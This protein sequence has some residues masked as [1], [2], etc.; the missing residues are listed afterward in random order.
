MPRP[1]CSPPSSA[2]IRST[3]SSP[4]ACARSPISRRSTRATYRSG[5]DIKVH[6]TLANGKPY[7][8]TGDWSFVSNQV[9]QQTDTVSVRA[10]FPNPQR[11]LVDGAFVTV[12]VEQGAPEPRLV[13]PRSALQLD[14]I[15]VYVLV[16]DDDNKAQVRR[17]TTAEA[18]Q[19]RNRHRLR[20]EG[21]RQGDRR[22]HPEGAAGS[23]RQRD[24]TIGGRGQ[25]VISSIFVDRPRLAFVIS[26]VITLAGLLA[27][28]SIPVAQ[29]PDIVPPQVTLTANYPGADAELG[30]DHR[31][32]ADR[33]AGQRRRQ[34]DLLSIDQ[35]RRRHLHAQRHVRARHQ[36]RHRHRQRAEPRDA[37]AAAI[38]DRSRAA[39]PVDPQEI[40]GA[41]AGADALFARKRATTS[42]SSPTMRPSTCVDAISRIKG[43]GQATLFGPLDY[44]LRVW[45]DPARL[46]AF[47]LDARRRRGGDQGAEHA[48]R[49][50]HDRRRAGRL[51]PAQRV[52]GQDHGPARQRRR[53][54][55]HR[56]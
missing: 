34:R 26:I 41:A 56:A 31:R 32:A 1:A 2:T 38:A 29:F 51:R 13:I 53:V 3:S 28:F 36:S 37:G 54:Q 11:A 21:R 15:G 45:L 52:H 42:C 27:I 35:R 5:T 14:Q 33:G 55:Q 30:R 50:R 39:G 44:S 7:D 12:K 24:A 20:V 9:D 16:V 23:G 22:R 25:A 48:G 46:A 18:R 47:S 8:Q 43:V 17:V 4:S 49:A 10:T 19:H 6:A 40:G